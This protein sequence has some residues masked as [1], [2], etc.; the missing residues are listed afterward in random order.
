MLSIWKTNLMDMQSSFSGDGF[1]GVCGKIDDI[2][3]YFVNVSLLVLWMVKEN[4]GK[5]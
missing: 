2:V 1:I 5:I 4:Y 3:V